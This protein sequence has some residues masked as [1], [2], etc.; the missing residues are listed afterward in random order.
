MWG[1]LGSNGRSRGPCSVSSQ[2]FPKYFSSKFGPLKID[3]LKSLRRA[4][5]NN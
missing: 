4:E 5:N 2:N 1:P 3:F